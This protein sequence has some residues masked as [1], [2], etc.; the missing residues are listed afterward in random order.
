MNI[1]IYIA[2]YW[3]FP[4]ADGC[5]GLTVWERHVSYISSEALR[6]TL[7]PVIKKMMTF[8]CGTICPLVWRKWNYQA[9]QHLC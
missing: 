1:Y 4:I 2:A 3:L 8:I 5:G 9:P 6:S 7:A